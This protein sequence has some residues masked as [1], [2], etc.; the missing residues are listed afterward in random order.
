MVLKCNLHTVITHAPIVNL[1]AHQ[2]LEDVKD[3]QHFFS[4]SALL[5]IFMQLTVG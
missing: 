2:T 1:S 4:N 3:M 5:P